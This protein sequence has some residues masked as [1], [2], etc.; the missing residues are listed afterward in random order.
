[1]YKHLKTFNEHNN[2]YPEAYEGYFDDKELTKF[3]KSIGGYG[4]P[5]DS[6]SYTNEEDVNDIYEMIESMIFNGFVVQRMQDLP[7]K[8]DFISTKEGI[9]FINGSIVLDGISKSEFIKKYIDYKN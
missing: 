1:M 7:M 2:S 5:K 9:K 6:Y 3:R 8:N 4:E